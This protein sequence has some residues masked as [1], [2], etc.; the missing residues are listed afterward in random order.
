MATT[1]PPRAPQQVKAAPQPLR[2][3]RDRK[4]LGTAAVVLLALAAVV[5]WF[6]ITSGRRKEDFAARMLSQAVATADRGNL[7]Q[8]ASDLQR[9]IQTYRGTEA[10]GEAVLL[11]NQIRLTTGQAELAAGNLREFL[12]SQPPPRYAAPAASL[13]G[14]ALESGNKFAEAAQAY[15]RAAGLADLDYMRA[16]YLLEA[17]RAFREAGRTQDAIRVYRN[18]VEKYP[19]APAVPEAQ[20]RLAELTAGAAGAGAR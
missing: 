19:S 17:G 6:V 13:L 5:A 20:L 8:A 10:A 14:A 7:P 2:W 1:A 15:E 18:I 12:A 4:R 11:L 16:A 9:L 3:Y